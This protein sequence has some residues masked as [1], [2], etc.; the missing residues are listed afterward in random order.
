MMPN[1]SPTQPKMLPYLPAPSRPRRHKIVR[2]TV[3]ANRLRRWLQFGP[4][5]VTE[6]AHAMQCTRYAIYSTLAI[7]PDVTNDRGVVAMRGAA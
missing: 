1:H 3:R 2:R 6:L 7:M 4:S 5:H